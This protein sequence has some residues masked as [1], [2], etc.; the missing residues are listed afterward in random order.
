MKISKMLVLQI[1]KM[2][3]CFHQ[4]VHS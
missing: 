2:T 3:G 1:Y 4:S